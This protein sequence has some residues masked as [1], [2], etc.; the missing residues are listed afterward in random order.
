M[1]LARTI[2][3]TAE[4]MESLGVKPNHLVEQLIKLARQGPRSKFEEIETKVYFD[5]IVDEKIR[6]CRKYEDDG[7]LGWMDYNSWN[8]L[9]DDVRKLFEAELDPLRFTGVFFK[10]SA[11]VQLRFLLLAGIETSIAVFTLRDGKNYQVA[12]VSSDW[13]VCDSFGVYKFRK[14]K[15]EFRERLMDTLGKDS[16]G[17]LIY[18]EVLNVK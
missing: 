6:K 5:P 1:D 13:A 18:R 2:I 11:Y 8:T 15:N 14:F 16:N 9:P 17:N 4:Q 10:Y 3:D 7:D 12:C